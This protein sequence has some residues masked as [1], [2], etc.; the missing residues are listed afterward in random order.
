MPG[1]YWCGLFIPLVHGTWLDF[2]AL[3]V[4]ATDFLSR[5][6]LLG[7]YLMF[8]P[9]FLGKVEGICSRDIL[10][11][12]VLFL[13]FTFGVDL[14]LAISLKYNDS[15]G[16]LYN[17]PGFISRDKSFP[18]LEIGPFPVEV[19]SWDLF[20]GEGS[21]VLSTLVSGVEENLLISSP[22]FSLLPYSLSEHPSLSIGECAAMDR[23][24][25]IIPY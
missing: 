11:S 5:S 17:W 10:A 21:G 22:E 19:D 1:R 14:D 13:G 7:V 16:I 4:A 6:A 23:L 15:D 24:F 8:R 9:V 20:F 3:E 2:P 25:S 18:L 12:I